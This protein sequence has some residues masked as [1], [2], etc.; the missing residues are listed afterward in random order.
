MQEYKSLGQI[1]CIVNYV[2]PIVQV[3]FYACGL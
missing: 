1:S 2:E 3:S